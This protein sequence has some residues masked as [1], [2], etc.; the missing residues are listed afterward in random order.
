MGVFAI[1]IG[2]VLLPLLSNID[3]ENNKKDFVANVKKS[4]KIVLLIGLPSCIGIYF[5]AEHIVTTIFFRGEFTNFDVLKTSLSLE[6]LALGLPF[7]MLMKI[8]IPTFFS[9]KLTKIPVLIAFI[10]LI[11]N[12]VLNY[13]FAFVYG[14]G[15]VGIAMGSSI[16]ALVSVLILESVLANQGIIKLSSPLNR[17]NLSLFISCV[18]LSAFLYLFNQYFHF[19]NLSALMRAFLLFAEVTAAVLI[20]FVCIKMLLGNEFKKLLSE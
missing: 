13:L 18:V 17:F 6:V 1:A 10:S 4:Q 20:Y 12:I 8:L 14:Y 5:C 2:T 15:H 19:M 9:R 11:L 3:F 16:A 7:F